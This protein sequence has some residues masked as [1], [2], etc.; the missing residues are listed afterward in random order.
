M[1]STSRRTFVKA[2]ALVG[3][4]AAFASVFPAG[5]LLL[6]SSGGR[7]VPAQA[8]S[9]KTFISGCAPDCEQNCRL[10]VRVKDGKMV[11]TEPAPMLNARYNRIC[12]R[13]LSHVQR[14]YHPDR[15]KYPMRRVGKRGEG[16]WERITWDQ[17]IDAIAGKLGEIKSQYGSNAVLFLPYAGNFGVVN[18]GYLGA[19]TMFAN[20]FGATVASNAVDS[21]LPLGES[22]VLANIP[23]SDFAHFEGNEVADIADHSRVI[24]A[25][26]MD[27]AETQLQNWHFIED[28][29]QNG[30]KFIVID[31]RFS[32]T[33]SKADIWIRP[34]PGSDC[35]L[36][37]SMIQVVM[38]EGLFDTTFLLEHT[39]APFLVRTD[40]GKFLR[41]GDIDGTNSDKYV[42]WDEATS[43]FAAVDVARQPALTAVKTFN[44]ILCKTAFQLLKEAMAEYRPEAVQGIT[45]VSPDEIRMLARTYATDK[46]SAI[47]AGFGIDRWDNADL[48]GR[49]LATLAA[50]TH[51]IG[52]PGASVGGFFGGSSFMA[53][54]RESW[55]WTAPTWSWAPSLNILLC[56]DAVATGKCQMYVPRDPSKPLLGTT[57]KDP[58]TVPYALKAA[59]ITCSNF[60][61]N[62]PAQKRIINEVLAE[63]RLEFVVVADEFMTD[64]ASYADIVLPST[65]WF[66]NDDLLVALHP[67]MVIQEKA[68]E[69]LYEA[70]SNWDFFKL[71]AEKMGF[72]QYFQGTSKD[73]RDRI[74][75]AL[76][77]VFGREKMDRLRNEGI[78]RLS[79]EPYVGFS[80]YNFPTP[81]GRIEFYAERVIVNFPYTY[82]ALGVLVTDG[83]DPLP[84]FR[85]PAEAWFENPLA[86]KYPLVCIQKHPLWRVHSQWFNIPWL[87]E[88]DPFPHVDIN[89]ADAR[90]RS[91]TEGDLVDVFN[92]RGSATLKARLTEALPPGM[93]NIDKGWQRSQ[94]AAGGYQ[95][96]TSDR[97]NPITLNASFFDT[98]V[99]VRKHGGA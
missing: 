66:E 56:Y 76:Q 11:K 31:P 49:A 90:A 50:L 58:V 96:L 24:I 18:G 55:R 29:I 6:R 52:L 78:T 32:K 43:T 2:M 80:D 26:G 94:F 81:S 10:Y 23:G 64:T 41:Q 73:M 27:T 72:G 85:P 77:E 74:I 57:S 54:A 68:I 9:E 8:S 89:P 45:N 92:D 79:D 5:D 83:G 33:A 61:S 47:L 20:V 63:D 15:L 67:Y 1:P 60:V 36:A 7:F 46:P 69:P 13:G 4:V 28:A 97:K 40:N 91:I 25:W 88:L 82:P 98:L 37:L 14:V 99:E 38:E 71:L 44:G 21:A 70:K 59:I 48:T 22:Q 53:V 75:G 86:G 93:I 95:E 87:R 16:K 62:L 51:N 19:M 3:G 30:A 17:A 12:L 84:R 42:V 65:S 39:V 34:R 35:A